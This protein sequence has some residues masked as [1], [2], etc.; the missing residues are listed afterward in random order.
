MNLL[1]VPDWIARFNFPY[2]DFGDIP[3][4]AFDKINSQLD[5]IQSEQPVVSILVSAYNEEIN[6][7]KCVAS[8]SETKSKF[9]LEIV[10]TNNNSNDR[11]QDT[12]DHLKVSSVFQGIQGWGP[13]RQKGLE[14][15]KGK[16]IL[17]ADADCIYPS[18][19]VDE[20][21]NVLSKPEVVCVYGR[22][23]FLPENG[24]PRWKLS[25]LEQLKNV[26]AEYR[27]L[28][29][30]YLNTYGISMGF[31]REYALKIGFV[32]EKVRGEDGRMAFDLM[33]YGSI[34]QVRSTKAIVWTGPRTL[35]RDGSFS[36][37]LRNR[38]A[39]EFGRFF[40]LMTAEKPHDT[41]KSGN[42]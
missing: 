25:L 9:P 42:D 35:E 11:T 34:K 15:A 17:L 33:K 16:Y 32:M 7:L 8:L 22:Y 18:T 39:K 36:K 10:V 37:V 20:M 12:L 26:I 6:I 2:K 30:P 13:A 41:K 3:Q 4:S 27:H 24:F 29:R 28:K 23:S 5:S 21:I 1:T 19:W 40:Q 38:I 14:T 31:I